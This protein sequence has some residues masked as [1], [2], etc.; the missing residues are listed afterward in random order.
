MGLNFRRSDFKK[1][2]F[3][4]YSFEYSSEIFIFES[5]DEINSKE[6]K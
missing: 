4:S 2:N 3:V 1:F 6:L 5:D